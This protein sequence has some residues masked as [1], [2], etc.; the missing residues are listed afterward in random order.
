[1]YSEEEAKERKERELEEWNEETEG[2]PIRGREDLSAGDGCADSEGVG[3]F[4]LRPP[5]RAPSFDLSVP[6][7]HAFALTSLPLSTMSR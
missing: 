5:A 1:M 2:R 3:A 4:P 6:L 7:S